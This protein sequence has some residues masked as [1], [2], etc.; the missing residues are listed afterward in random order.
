MELCCTLNCAV[1]LMLLERLIMIE[2]QT[3]TIIGVNDIDILMTCLFV[4]GETAPQWARAS[5]FTRFLPLTRCITVGRT[6][7]D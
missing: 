7:L 3:V 6:P 1:H 2:F 4:F 5:S